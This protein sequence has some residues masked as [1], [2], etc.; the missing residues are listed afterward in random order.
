MTTLLDIGPGQIVVRRADGSTVFNSATRMPHIL[1][2]ISLT[3]VSVEFPAVPGETF[4]G[5]VHN[6]P[7]HDLFTRQTL[8]AYPSSVAPQFWWAKARLTQTVFGNFGSYE[9]GKMFLDGVTQPWIGSLFLERVRNQ[10][11]RHMN[12]GVFG[13]NIVLEKRQSGT[14]RSTVVNVF[15]STRSV[16]TLDADIAWGVFDQ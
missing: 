9:F 2:T 12:L 7:A 5:S 10:M 8:A 15:C 6:T 1:G 14:G 13:G 3:G 16:F 11:I 4:T